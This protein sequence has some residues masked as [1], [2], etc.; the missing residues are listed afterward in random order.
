MLAEPAESRPQGKIA[1]P[2][3][4]IRI[5]LDHKNRMAF[6]DVSFLDSTL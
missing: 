1:R 6:S 2:P 4:T 5:G 3:V